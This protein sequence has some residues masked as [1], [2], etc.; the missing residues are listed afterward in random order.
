MLQH[1]VESGTLSA[2]AIPGVTVGGKTG[3]GDV[4]DDVEGHY[5][6]DEYNLTFAGMF[7]ID[8]P[9]VTMVVMLHRP[10][11]EGSSSTYVAAPLFRRIGSEVVAHWGLSPQPTHRA[12]Q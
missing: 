9:R 1:T 12:E 10:Q 2:A 8:R 4:F 3:T 11:V 6:E 5:I 7:P